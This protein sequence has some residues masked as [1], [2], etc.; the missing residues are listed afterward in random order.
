MAANCDAGS[1]CVTGRTFGGRTEKI[2]GCTYT[3]GV[4]MEEFP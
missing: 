3:F 2:P 4:C 1:F